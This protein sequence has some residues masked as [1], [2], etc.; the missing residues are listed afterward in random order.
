MKL[1]KI[2]RPAGRGFFEVGPL[3]EDQFGVWLYAPRGSKWEAPHAVGTLPFDALALLSPE[4]SW[5]AWWVDEPGDRR[6]EI[7]VCLAP[8]SENDGWSY[9]DLEL[10][11]VRHENGTTEI[12]DRDEFDAACRNGWISLQDAEMSDAT[13]K[14]MADV[15]R[16]GDE[17]FGEEG[18]RRLRLA[19]SHTDTNRGGSG[20]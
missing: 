10:D 3:G 16:R 4:R 15:L 18:W 7:D 9:V 14:M 6:V 5:V 11:L 17:P 19:K 8:Q 1:W 2:K 12:L 13:T 20:T